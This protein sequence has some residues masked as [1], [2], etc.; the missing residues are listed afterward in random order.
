MR[1]TCSLLTLVTTE[2]E[3]K[4]MVIS[5]CLF[6]SYIVKLRKNYFNEL[7]V[8]FSVKLVAPLGVFDIGPDKFVVK[9]CLKFELTSYH[10]VRSWHVHHL[11]VGIPVKNSD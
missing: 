7:F 4:F 10:E 1:R 6:A 5:S 3:A 9:S 2:I 11:T 8:R